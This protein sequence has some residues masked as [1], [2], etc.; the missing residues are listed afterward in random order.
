M[1]APRLIALTGYAGSGKSTV[2]EHLARAHG[3]RRI[4]FADPLKDMLKVGF[5][6]TD[7]HV[8]GGLKETPLD[9]LGGRS[10]RQAMQTLGTEW[11]RETMHPELWVRAWRARVDAS[12]AGVV[13]EDLRFLNEARMV[14]ARGGEI[15]RIHRPGCSAGGHISEQ[16]LDRITPRAVITNDGEIEELYPLIDYLLGM[17]PAEAA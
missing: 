6:L 2:A 14:R 9:V 11:G 1:T 10:P 3:Y 15:W 8:N 4:R 13:V 16:E 7:E 5:G 12:T 17:S